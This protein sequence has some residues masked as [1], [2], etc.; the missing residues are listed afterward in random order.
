VLWI[1]VSWGDARVK[2]QV[3]ATM[4][5]MEAGNYTCDYPCQSTGKALAGGCC[6]DVWQPYI[7]FTNIKYHPQ[8]GRHSRC[9]CCVPLRRAMQ[10]H[11]FIYTVPNLCRASSGPCRPLRHGLEPRG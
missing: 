4:A 3:V 8:V 11:L 9:G 5:K 10:Q 2:D 6:D 7:A 1:Y